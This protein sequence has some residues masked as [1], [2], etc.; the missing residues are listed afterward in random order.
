MQ[1]LP[2]ALIFLW[3][4]AVKAPASDF[5]ALESWKRCACPLKRIAECTTTQGAIRD[6]ADRRYLEWFNPSDLGLATLPGWREEL[7]YS[8]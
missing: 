5:G 7:R 6:I 8:G 3:S 2:Q 4:L 1:I